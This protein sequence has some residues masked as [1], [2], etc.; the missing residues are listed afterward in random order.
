L[1]AAKEEQMSDIYR[2]ALL[3]NVNFH[4]CED[5]QPWFGIPL[6]GITCKQLKKKKKKAIIE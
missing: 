1:C 6:V 4:F 5:R 2:V 3:K